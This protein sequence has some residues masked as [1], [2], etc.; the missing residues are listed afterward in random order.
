VFQ[1]RDDFP[2][3]IFIIEVISRIGL[4]QIRIDVSSSLLSIP[5]LLFPS[6]DVKMSDFSNKQVKPIDLPNIFDGL[7]IDKEQLPES[8]VNMLDKVS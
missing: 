7:H 8:S 5:S 4:P 3:F 1:I 2:F 6:S